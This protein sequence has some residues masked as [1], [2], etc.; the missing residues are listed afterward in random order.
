M[1]EKFFS[2]YVPA[3][4]DRDPPDPPADPAPVS[5]LV[6]S[7]CELGLFLFTHFG[8]CKIFKGSRTD[9]D[10]TV[11]VPQFSFFCTPYNFV[12]RSKATKK[13]RTEAIIESFEETPKEVF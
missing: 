11:H 9:P 3:F 12:F 2:P 10:N 6:S 8:V 5:E 4:R 7:A 1:K 13:N